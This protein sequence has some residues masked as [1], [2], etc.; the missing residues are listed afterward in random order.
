MSPNTVLQ[1]F[2]KYMDKVWVRFFSLP[3]IYFFKWK[4]V[5]F[6]L[7]HGGI[8]EPHEAPKHPSSNAPKKTTQLDFFVLLYDT[9]KIVT[10]FFFYIGIQHLFPCFN[11]KTER[12]AHQPHRH[13]TASSFEH[14]NG[15]H[16]QMRRAPPLFRHFTHPTKNTPNAQVCGYVCVCAL[17]D[18]NSRQSIRSAEWLL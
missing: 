18:I 3:I 6:S 11:T 4:P 8:K 2:V 5:V 10:D 15:E 9:K 13:E 12:N 16:D 1:R 7:N 17:C 14:K